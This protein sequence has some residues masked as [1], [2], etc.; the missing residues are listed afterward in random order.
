[1]SAKAVMFQIM[2]WLLNSQ[3]K[4]RPDSDRIRKVYFFAFEHVLM[5]KLELQPFFFPAKIPYLLKWKMS[6]PP[7]MAHKRVRLS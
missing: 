1:M 5:C 4:G 6:P 2:D 7:Q 3:T